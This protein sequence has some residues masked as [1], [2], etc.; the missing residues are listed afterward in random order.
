MQPPNSGLSVVQP[1]RRFA[2]CYRLL[3]L[4]LLAIGEWLPSPGW[5][6]LIHS[7]REWRLFTLLIPQAGLFAGASALL[8]RNPR[9]FCLALL[10]V[11]LV[12]FSRF[13]TLDAG[14]GTWPHL[15][16]RLAGFSI[17]AGAL[18]SGFLVPRSEGGSAL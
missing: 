18:W 8:Q 3:C 5:G 9:A 17:A 4:L 14:D 10:G 6:W 15:L 2:F 11:F 13:L 1:A 12:Q 16:V 7:A